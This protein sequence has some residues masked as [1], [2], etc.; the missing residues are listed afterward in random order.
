MRILLLLLPVIVHAHN[1][2]D[3]QEVDPRIKVELKYATEDNAIKQIVYNFTRCLLQQDVAYALSAV[4]NEL[5][6]LGLGLKV[7]DGYRPMAA[8]W[9]VWDLLPDM[10][11]PLKGGRN[12]RGTSVDLT[13]IT[14]NGAELEMPTGYDDITAKA[15]LNCQ[16]LPQTAINNRDILQKAMKKYGFSP[17]LT[18]W[19]HFDYM[20]W[21]DYPPLD[22]NVE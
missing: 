15:H 5:E 4:Q 9:K 8:Q 22:V 17:L 2:V 14:L 19:W 6:P 21:E 7:W 12:T 16:D 11:D 13:L 3:I 10:S 1:L 18:E 20:G